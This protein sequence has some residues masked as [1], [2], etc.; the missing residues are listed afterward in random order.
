MMMNYDHK[1]KYHVI[2]DLSHPLIPEK[3]D[4]HG[5]ATVCLIT[6]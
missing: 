1:W 2:A 6:D 3:H 5:C 4:Y